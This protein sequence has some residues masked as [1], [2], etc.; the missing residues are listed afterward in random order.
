MKQLP[1]FCRKSPKKM[2]EFIHECH[3]T[4]YAFDEL[5]EADRQ[6]VL[7]AQEAT[8]R[9]YAPYSHFH[10]GAAA[11]LNGGTIVIGSN[12]EN[13][14]FPSGL[15]AERTALFAAG[16]QYPEQSV[17]ALAIAAADA[18]GLTSIPTPPCGACRQVMLETETR[19]GCPMRILLYG[20]QGTFVFEGV[21]QLLP[22][23]FDGSFL[24][25]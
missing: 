20:T 9:S 8:K 22:L 7:S 18:N 2:K 16:A 21:K 24:R 6:L 19:S 13:A 10:V 23:T 14:A 25:E 4:L 12:Q 3:Y 1:Y 11:R 5:A 17:V 15:C